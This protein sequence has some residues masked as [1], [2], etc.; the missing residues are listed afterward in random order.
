M[1]EVIV[2]RNPL[3]AAIWQTVM[4]GE[5]FVVAVGL[6][7]FFLVFL[8]IHGLV[9]KYFGWMKQQKTVYWQLAGSAVVGILI[10]KYLWV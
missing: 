8:A 4:N 3:E 2:Y 5:F 1:Q 6:V 10:V 9:G 7:A